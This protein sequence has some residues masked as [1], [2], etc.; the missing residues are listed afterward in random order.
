MWNAKIS[1]PIAEILN[2]IANPP[3]PR[4]DPKQMGVTLFDGGQEEVM[5]GVISYRFDTGATARYGTAPEWELWI[6][7]P[8]GTEVTLEVTRI[9]EVGT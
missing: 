9:T 6:T 1:Q 7:L 3:N 8:D 2:L 5:T 4:P